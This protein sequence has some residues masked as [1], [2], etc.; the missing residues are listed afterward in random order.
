MS[1]SESEV[2]LEINQNIRLGDRSSALKRIEN[3]LESKTLSKQ[4]RLNYQILKA[5]ALTKSDKYFQS[6]NVLDEIEESTSKIGTDLQKLDF[7]LSKIENLYVFGKTTLGMSLVEEAES[8][9]QKISDD[10]SHNVTH[11]RIDLLI[12]KSCMISNIYGYIDK[13]HEVLELC[14]KLCEESDY[15]YGKALTLERMSG[16]FSEMGKREEAAE[17]AE[18]AHE[19]WKQLENKAG[20]AYSTFLKGLFLSATDSDSALNLLKQSI[21]LNK[22]ID[23]NL[24]ISKIHNS[25]AILLF[26][27]DEGEEALQ[28]LET[29]INIKRK[30]G[31]KHG[32]ILLLYNIGQLYIS[33]MENEKALAFLHEGL[34]LTKELDYQRPYYLI[35]FALNS[36]YIRR[37]E[38]NR[39]L[40]FLEEAVLFYEEKN[41]KED[42]AWTREKLADILVMK[43]NLDAALQNY[44]QSQEFYEKENRTANVCDVLNNIAEI[45]QLRGEY[46][47]ALKYYQR[48]EELAIKSENYFILAKLT[49]NL[50]LYHLDMNQKG[51]SKRYLET[52]MSL[53]E[54]FKS[55][56][57]EILFNLANALVIINDNETQSRHEAKELLKNILKEE[58]VEHKL[59]ST[60]ILNLCRLLIAELRET[61]NLDLM[62]EL[63][64]Y[65]EMMHKE[66]SAELAYPLLVQS[67]W[68]QANVALVELDTEKAIRLLKSAQV[69]AE[70]KEFHNLARRISNNHDIL[71]GQ[72]EQWETFTMKLPNIAERM[73]LTHIESVLNDMIKGKGIVY[74][75]DIQEEEAPILVSIFTKT[76]SVLY[77]EGLEPE[78]DS[79]MMEQIWIFILKS[80]KEEDTRSGIIERR[81]FGEYSY[82]IKRIESLIFCYVFMGNSYGG[83][84]KIDEF[85][86]LVYGTM[87]IWEELE[88]LSKISLTTEFDLD[89]LLTTSTEESSL[90]FSISSILN[91]YVDNIF[92]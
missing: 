67:I 80:I 55:K 7:Y 49:Y 16:S 35:Q 44:I 8:L 56:K 43:G 12:I 61:E 51:D 5:K 28:H 37:G 42:V 65:V 62:N 21:E 10:K 54:K 33:T 34:A 78:I 74:S 9:I 50:T 76:G 23:A 83:L 91:Q 24:T 26:Q 77:I 39:A 69:M 63:K 88:E 45:H 3:F 87:E 57:I 58:N 85:S 19:I 32:L 41:M 13:L 53:N 86:Q 59:T 40:R 31:D 25:L 6:M 89:T 82:V 64:S 2:L 60:A 17:C 81:K 20:I 4:S 68:L 1:D 18:R 22:E 30:I 36:L 46:D 75:E 15:E 38:L 72:L 48:G 92:L 27:K 71:L 84:K 29:S 73:E 47:L 70:A 52:L 66:G 14:L 79:Q 90:E 11:R